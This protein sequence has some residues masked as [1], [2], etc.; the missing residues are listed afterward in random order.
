MT[1]FNSEAAV[2]QAREALNQFKNELAN[3]IGVPLKQRLQWRPDFF[4]SMIC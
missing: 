2:P 1:N 3:E 4:S